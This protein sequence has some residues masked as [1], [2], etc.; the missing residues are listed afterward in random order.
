MP[1]W[2][3]HLCVAY[4]V[5]A[6]VGSIVVVPILV[7]VGYVNMFGAF[8]ITAILLTIFLYIDNRTNHGKDFDY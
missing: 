6:L 4:L 5:I 1:R 2:V 7:L 8:L 3:Q